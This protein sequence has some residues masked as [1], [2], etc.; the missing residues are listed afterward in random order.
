M[1]WLFFFFSGE[2]GP[3]HVACETLVSRPGIKPVTPALEAWSLNH[4]T[5]R[6]VPH[7]PPYSL[8][9]YTVHT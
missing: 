7:A 9:M 2:E 6:E 3:L 4:W 8:S 1:F 5:S